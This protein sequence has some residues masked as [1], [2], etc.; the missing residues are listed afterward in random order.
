MLGDEDSAYELVDSRDAIASTW[1]TLPDAERKVL[2][3]RFM[4]DLTQREI[5]DQIGYS[6]MH[7]SRLLRPR[8][9]FSRQPRQRLTNGVRHDRRRAYG[10]R[11]AHRQVEYR[12]ARPRLGFTLWALGGPPDL[13]SDTWSVPVTGRLTPAAAHT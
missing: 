3:L 6:R 8:S 10:L 12:C 2:E 9:T 4:H 13:G 11:V 1:K 7:V 5:G